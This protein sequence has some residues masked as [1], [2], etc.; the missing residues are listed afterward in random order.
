MMVAWISVE[1]DGLGRRVRFKIY[2]SFYARYTHGQIR[3]T[4]L[5]NTG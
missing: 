5:E 2:F 1:A 4:T 3:I